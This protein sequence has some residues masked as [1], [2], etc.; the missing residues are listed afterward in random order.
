MISDEPTVSDDT[1]SPSTSRRLDADEIEA[2]IEAAVRPGTKAQLT[3]LAQKLRR[4]SSALSRVEASKAKLFEEKCGTPV[5]NA[6][7]AISSEKRIDP[8]PV[9]PTHQP[10]TTNVSASTVFTP[11]AKFA[12]DAGEHNSQFF[13]LYLPLVGVGA[14]KKSNVDAVTCKFTKHSFDFVALG[15]D[16]KNYRLFKDN[17]E[18][19]IVPEKC[20]IIVKTDKVIIKLAKVKGEYSY[21]HWAQ[22]TAKKAKSSKTDKKSNDPQD[23]I[24][25]LMKDM[26]DSGDD[27]MKKVI[28]EAMLK[29]RDKSGPPAYNDPMKDM[30]D[31]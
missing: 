27:K 28:G 10:A 6:H 16:G 14:H 9:L 18:K 20:K 19:D 17:L 7:G 23:S 31:F 24:M 1:E 26:Y 21:D 15:L 13:T 22:L 25:D 3:L 12:F 5:G 4:E 29:S 2:L 11:I 30:D 8:I